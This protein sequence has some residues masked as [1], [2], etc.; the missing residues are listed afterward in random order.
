MTLREFCNV[1]YADLIEGR[2]S[3]QIADLDLLL[4]KGEEALRSR[5]QR[6]AL[7]QLGAAAAMPTRR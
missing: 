3:E 5:R 7:R 1:A 4:A 2:T 6:E